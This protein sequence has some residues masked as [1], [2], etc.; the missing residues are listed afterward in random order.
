MAWRTL[1]RVA[2]ASVLHTWSGW[3]VPRSGSGGGGDGG[4]A[5]A[6]GSGRCRPGAGGIGPR[7]WAIVRLLVHHIQGGYYGDQLPHSGHGQAAARWWEA[8]P[9]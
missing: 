3:N 4:G 5:G 7:W 6:R 9:G 8:I 1:R 2:A